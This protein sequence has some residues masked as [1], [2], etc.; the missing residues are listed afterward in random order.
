MKLDDVQDAVTGDDPFL[1][2]L[3]RA[4]RLLAGMPG[5]AE[6]VRKIISQPKEEWSMVIKF[7][8]VF[9]AALI[10]LLTVGV[11]TASLEDQ[12][13]GMTQ[14]RRI[15]FAGA[16]GWILPQHRRFLLTLNGLRN[17]FA[18]KPK[19]ID[20]TIATYVAD[21]DERR[22][23]SFRDGINAIGPNPAPSLQKLAAEAPAT[24]IMV[25]SIATLAGL[26][27]L[28]NAHAKKRA[29]DQQAAEA[30]DKFLAAIANVAHES[31]F[32]LADEQPEQQKDQ[33]S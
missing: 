13:E 20:A 3:N 31:G 30:W 19:Y 11:G 22:Q 10:H 15:E 16:A 33:P 14:A 6:V 25:S 1:Q 21:L 18:H 28:K 26:H 23:Q 24:M 4:Y 29:R 2:S 27:D 17:Q 9:E 32:K 8:A 7:N 5:A 12:F